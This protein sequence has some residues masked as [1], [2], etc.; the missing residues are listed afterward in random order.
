MVYSCTLKIKAAGSFDITVP[1]YIVPQ[2]RRQQ[3]SRK[4][5][6]LLWNFGKL[7]RQMCWWSGIV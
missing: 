6:I 3:T 5:N 2:H 4:L 1:D 7:L